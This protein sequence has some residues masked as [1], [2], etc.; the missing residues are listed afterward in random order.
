MSTAVPGVP[1]VPIVPILI[2]L[3]VPKLLPQVKRQWKRVHALWVRVPTRFRVLPR[4]VGIPVVLL[5]Q[6]AWGVA[7]HRGGVLRE[8][9]PEHSQQAP[10]FP[11]C[12]KLF[13][14]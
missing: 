9:N 11:L 7:G 4:P 6:V 1:I 13:P 14:V 12:P 2:V 10:V 3:I 5:L 8:D